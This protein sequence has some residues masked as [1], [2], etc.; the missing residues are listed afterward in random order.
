MAIFWVH[1]CILV[2]E[3]APVIFF[4]I[5]DMTRFSTRLSQ[6]GKIESR[7]QVIA[8][9]CRIPAAR[10][11]ELPRWGL[12]NR[13]QFRTSLGMKSSCDVGVSFGMDYSLACNALQFY[14]QHQIM[15]ERL[16]LGGDLPQANYSSSLNFTAK[17]MWEDGR[18]FTA[19]QGP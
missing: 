6:T 15:W 11:G 14:C 3:C 7:T 9:G 2:T 5:R 16:R 19:S 17:I 8:A 18:W 13:T 4:C 12:H 10:D 1:S